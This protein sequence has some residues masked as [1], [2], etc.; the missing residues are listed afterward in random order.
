LAVAAALVAVAA[1]AVA[2]LVAVAVEASA[3]PPVAVMWAPPVVAVVEAAAVAPQ[4]R[5][6]SCKSGVSEQEWVGSEDG[7]DGR[8]ER[9]LLI[10]YEWWLLGKGRRVL[11]TK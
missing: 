8:H 11:G 1:L 7:P 10:R 2:A 3:G 4:F 9:R 6:T 5:A